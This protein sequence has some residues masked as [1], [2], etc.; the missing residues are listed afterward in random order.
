MHE[1]KTLPIGRVIVK[2]RRGNRYAF[3]SERIFTVNNIPENTGVAEEI[4]GKTI[5]YFGSYHFNNFMKGE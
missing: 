5:I 2:K 3:V 1:Q 4:L